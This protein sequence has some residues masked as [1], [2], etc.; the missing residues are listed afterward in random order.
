[1]MAIG[2]WR[3]LAATVAVRAVPLLVAILLCGLLPTPADGVLA[4]LFGLILSSWLHEAGHVVAYWRVRRAPEPV[5][6]R[7]ML[8]VATSV[9]VDDPGARARLVALGG[10]LPVAVAGLIL[11]TI[12]GVLG[13]P[14]LWGSGIAFAVH[15][16]GLLPG[17]S[18]GNRI[19]GLQPD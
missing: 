17:C 19:C 10:P 2:S 11:C 3:Q 6:I 16:G 15:L 12:A 13:H 14:V 8:E 7:R 5:V 4:A 18:D 9:V 1:M